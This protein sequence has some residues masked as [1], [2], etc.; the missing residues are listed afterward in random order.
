MDTGSINA[1][2]VKVAVYN[3][4]KFELPIIIREAIDTAFGNYWNDVIGFGNYVNF[5]ET[6]NYIDHQLKKKK[7][8]FSY[9]KLEHI[10]NIIYDYIEM[11]GGFLDEGT[12]SIPRAPLPDE[13]L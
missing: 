11:A 5:E 12:F 2:R 1:D 9:G 13:Y 6:V 8:M 7:I 4:I 3:R 10:V